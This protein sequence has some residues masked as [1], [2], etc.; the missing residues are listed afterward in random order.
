VSTTLG[1][2]LVVGGTRSGVGKTTVATGVMAALARRGRKVA[3]AKVGPDFIDPGYHA[4]ATGRPG[5]NLDIWMSGADAIA[6]LAGRAAAGAEILVVEGVMGLFDGAA[7]GTPSSTAEVAKRLHAPVVLVVDASAMSQSVAATVHGYRTWDPA[8]RVEGVILNMVASDSH[9]RMLRAALEPT[10]VAVLGALARDDA[11]AWRSRHLGLV[12]V[13]ENPA[14]VRAS[15]DRLAAVIE[16]R[17]DLDGLWRLAGGAAPMTTPPVPAPTPVPPTSS[18]R[19]RVAVAAGPAFSFCYP[20]NLEALTAAGAEVVPFDPCVDGA[21]P[22]GIGAVVAGGGFPEVFADALA[23]NRPMLASLRAHHARGGVIWAE[24]GGL[25]WLARSLDGRPMAGLV[26]AE[27]ALTSTRVLGYRT[28]RT[29]TASPLGPAGTVVRGHEFHYS[30]TDP[31]GAALAL[32]GR[33]GRSAGGFATPRLLASYL[34]IHL[35]AR[36][37]LAEAIVRAAAS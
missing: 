30:A 25:C 14:A 8:V 15:L 28:A 22:A 6:P 5:R 7:D 33:H 32:S 3:A 35:A 13:A 9:E 11:L 17:C 10:G 34:H 4:V 20:D 29:T 19:V 1:P 31:A 26:D 36:P 2:R 21:L 24:C 37:D 16:A 12:P 27:A 23:A 18:G